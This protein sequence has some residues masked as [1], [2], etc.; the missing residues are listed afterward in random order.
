MKETF[1]F[2]HDYN[3]RNDQKITMLRGKYGNEGYAVFFYLLETMA[4]E[5][6]GYIYREAIGGLSVGYG[7]AK[8]W[9]LEFI[10]YCLHINL[11]QEDNNGIFSIRMNKHKA[12]RL[13][14][15]QKGKE[16]AEKRWSESQNN[17]PPNGTPLAYK[18]KERKEKERKEEC[19]SDFSK[20]P[21]PSQTMKDFVE[22][23]K[24]KNERYEPFVLSIVGD[25]KIPREI[26]IKELDK[27]V[28]YWTELNK[29]GT[30]ERWELEKVFEVQRRLATWLSRTH[31]FNPEKKSRVAVINY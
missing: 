14:L 12:T 30:R 18:G 3:A 6:H 21:T 27:F 28:N 17:S 2:S 31:Q 19:I 7:V 8:D 23:V 13:L 22:M 29:S 25:K 15:K 1:Y 10:E 16:G 24:T 20:S 9:L 4:E 26:I 11:L 5:E